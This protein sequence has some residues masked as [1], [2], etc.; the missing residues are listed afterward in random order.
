MQEF[1]RTRAGIGEERLN[2]VG[3]TALPNRYY[4]PA[5]MR[6]IA[7]ARAMEWVYR[8]SGVNVNSLAANNGWSDGWVP[9][10]RTNNRSI[11]PRID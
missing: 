10:M 6:R 3:L 7:E 8:N 9:D 5:R 1:I 4:T 2:L 11:G